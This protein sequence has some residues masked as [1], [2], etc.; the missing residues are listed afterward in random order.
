M[1]V[2]DYILDGLEAELALE[3]ELGVRVVECDRSL[4]KPP[5]PPAA[6][7]PRPVEP[8]RPDEPPPKPVVPPR[9]VEPPRPPKPVVL[10]RP[11]ETPRH[12]SGG[13]SPRF[14]FL[15]HKP[16]SPDAEAMMSKIV[17]AMG[18][19][20][21]TAPVVYDDPVPA[22]GVYIVLGALAMRRWLP[23]AKAA[24][25]G[26]LKTPRGA[27]ALVTYSPEKIVRYKVV[28]PAV[29]QMKLDMWTS[30]KGAMRRLA[31]AAK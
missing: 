28:T 11:V 20:P 3:R 6:E 17:A 22:A 4:L 14:V 18:E 8:P 1:T 25:G 10:P 21:Q 24:P 2:L 12:A 23:G 16:L 29:K 15:H 5:A 19:S 27:D 9:P 26:W 13:G 31:G 30:L 7:P